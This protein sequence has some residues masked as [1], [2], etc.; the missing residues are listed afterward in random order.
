MLQLRLPIA[1]SRTPERIIK[2]TQTGSSSKAQ[3]SS[4]VTTEAGDQLGT[5][6]RFSFG[7]CGSVE[8]FA[9]NTREIQ[10]FAA[11]S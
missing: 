8:F 6:Q 7:P 3:R 11:S 5:K 10:E 9:A 4:Q 1:A 2:Q